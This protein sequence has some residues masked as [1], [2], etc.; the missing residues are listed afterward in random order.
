MTCGNAKEAEMAQETF[1]ET[2]SGDCEEPENSEKSESNESE[3]TTSSNVVAV[4][5]PLR[6]NSS[7]NSIAK[8]NY[9]LIS[10]CW[11]SDLKDY[12]TTLD[13]FFSFWNIK[14]V[15]VK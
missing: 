7:E 1:S 4:S 15:P 11:W 8:D 5:Q 14:Y 2:R 12:R 6:W 10:S 9:G 3:H 13:I